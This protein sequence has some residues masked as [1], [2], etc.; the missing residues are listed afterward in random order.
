MVEP[1]PA[2]AAWFERVQSRNG[3]NGQPTYPSLSS[4]DEVQN[5]RLKSVA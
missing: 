3:A 4:L 1:F 2:L 5:K